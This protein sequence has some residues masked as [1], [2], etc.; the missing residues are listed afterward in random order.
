MD[1]SANNILKL[2]GKESK[3]IGQRLECNK[4]LSQRSC[5][6]F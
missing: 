6:C 3:E 1:V 5:F 2:F 4:W